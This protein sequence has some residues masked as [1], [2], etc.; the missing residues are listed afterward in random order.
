MRSLRLRR[1]GRDGRDRHGSE[2]APCL[3]RRAVRHAQLRAGTYESPRLEI[4]INGRFCE[5]LHVDISRDR[6][7]ARVYL[8]VVPPRIGEVVPIDGAK[9][10][11]WFKSHA[12][13]ETAKQERFPYTI[14]A[15]VDFRADAVLRHSSATVEERGTILG[16]VRDVPAAQDI[17][18]RRIEWL[19]TARQ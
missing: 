10:G 2:N 13:G 4:D 7:W 18:Q 1:R 5:G 6:Q 9:G 8:D 19:A 11:Y 14:V 15:Y 16:L 12:G 3:G 17:R